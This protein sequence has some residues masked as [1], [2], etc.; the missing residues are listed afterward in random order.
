MVF[1]SRRQNSATLQYRIARN[2]KKVLRWNHHSR[3]GQFL[4][5]SC[6]EPLC[7]KGVKFGR[8]LTK[9]DK[10]LF[11][12]SPYTDSSEYAMYRK[13]SSSWCSWNKNGLDHPYI[14]ARTL[15]VV[16]KDWDIDWKCQTQ[17][18]K[19]FCDVQ[20]I[21]KKLDML[22]ACTTKMTQKS[23][24]SKTYSCGKRAVSTWYK[25]PMVAEVGGITLF[26]KKKSASSGLRLILFLMRK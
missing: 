9:T 15:G 16:K 12:S 26:T 10:K 20:L 13:K 7:L 14:F 17:V 8:K 21:K 2:K 4:A 1:C 6:P 19:I 24:S 11:Y 3:F 18:Q 25:E 5:Q 23:H 22:S